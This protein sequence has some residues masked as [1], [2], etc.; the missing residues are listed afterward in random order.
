MWRLFKDCSSTFSFEAGSLDQTQ[1]LS[2][3]D[4][5]SLLSEPGITGQP[6]CTPTLS[7]YVSLGIQAL[8]LLLAR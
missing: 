8:V 2:I 4:L 6:V 7:S 1:S 3:Q 5:P